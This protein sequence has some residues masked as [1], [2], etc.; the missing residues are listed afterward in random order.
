MLVIKGKRN[1]NK[2]TAQNEF[3]PTD[4]EDFSS[5]KFYVRKHGALRPQK[6][7][8]LVRDGEVGGSGI[9]I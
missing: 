8:R 4:I 3:V 9:Y 2:K 6:R 5:S 7:L 1:N